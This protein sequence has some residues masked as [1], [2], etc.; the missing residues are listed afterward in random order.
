MNVNSVSSVAA[1]SWMSQ[2]YYG[3]TMVGLE[4]RDGG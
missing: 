3:Q 1:T 2:D 4:A